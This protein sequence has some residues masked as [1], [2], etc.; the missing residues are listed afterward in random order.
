MNLKKKYLFHQLFTFC[1]V[2]NPLR[3]VLSAPVEAIEL[4]G[5]AVLDG[6]SV[7]IPCTMI[8][9]GKH[10]IRLK[11]DDPGIPA[12]RALV[13]VVMGRADAWLPDAPAKPDRPLRSFLLVC[14]TAFSV[15]LPQRTPSRKRINEAVPVDEDAPSRMF[16]WAS[17]GAF[18]ALAGHTHGGQ[19]RLPL[20]GTTISSCAAGRPL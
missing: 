10:G 14:Q 18:L 4:T 17:A 5:N 11:F 7:P 13:G 19:V 8:E 9:S 20:F 1:Q 6:A 12:R 16:Q 2:I 3:E 15:L